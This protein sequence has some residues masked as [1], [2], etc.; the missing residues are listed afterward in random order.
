MV[1]SVRQF[2]RKHY[3]LIGH[4]PHR[5]LYR[6]PEWQWLSSANTKMQSAT[7]A[8]EARASAISVLVREGMTASSAPSVG[9]AV[10]PVV[11]RTSK[12]LC[13]QFLDRRAIFPYI[14]FIGTTGNGDH[15][16]CVFIFVCVIVVPPSPCVHPTVV[17]KLLLSAVMETAVCLS[18]FLLTN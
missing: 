4:S 18:A 13:D 6:R 11:E 15:A 12:I 14:S 10:N 2:A 17:T 7:R 16:I 1:E 5:R 9:G 3:R 8:L